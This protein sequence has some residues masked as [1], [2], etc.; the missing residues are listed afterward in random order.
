MAISDRMKRKPKES[1]VIP[2]FGAAGAPIDRGHP[3]YFGFVATIGALSA[4]VLMRALASASQVFVLI[5]VALFLATGLNPAVEAIRKR[6]LSRAGAVAVIFAAVILFVGLFMALVVPPLISQGTHLIQIAPTLLENLKNNSSIA[7]LNNHYGVIDT[8]QKRLNSVTSDGTLL[9]SAFG[10]VIGVGKSV[11]SGTFTALTILI[12]TLYFI[13]SLPQAVELGLKLVPASRRIR[14]SLLTDAII[15]RVG[16]FVGS[17]ILVSFLAALFIAIFSAILGLPSP[18]AIAIIVFVCGLVPLIGHFLGCAI[19]TIIALTQ[20][21]SIGVIAFV[22]Y[23][24]YV[25][26]ENYIVHPRIMKRNLAVPGA[27]TIISAMIGTSL[28]GLVGGLLAV[29][30]AASII[31]ILEEVVFPRA[32]KS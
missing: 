4:F 2:D 32:E 8:L 24:V 27:V 20:S 18:V 21:L 14:V 10:G 9:I 3:F 11:L 30:V 31:L 15:A 17:Q 26:V 6:G 22:G 28:L 19:V 1:P 25:Q 29:P 23:V 7:N 16:T 5:L 13:T 12:L